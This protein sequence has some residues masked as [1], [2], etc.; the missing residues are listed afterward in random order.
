MKNCLVRMP[1]FLSLVLTPIIYT[2]TAK[3]GDN[4]K[5]ALESKELKIYFGSLTKDQRSSSKNSNEISDV[6]IDL[7]RIDY[8]TNKG[9]YSNSGKKSVKFN[10]DQQDNDDGNGISLGD[11][12][13]CSQIRLVVDKKKY[14]K[15]RDHFGHECTVKDAFVSIQLQKALNLQNKENNKLK[16]FLDMRESKFEYD[17]N[18]VCIFKPKFK[19]YSASHDKECIKDHEHDSDRDHDRERDDDKDHRG[20]KYAFYRN[21]DR[22]DRHSDSRN[23]ISNLRGVASQKCGG[24]NRWD[25]DDDDRKN[26]RPKQ[27][28][29]HG[30]VPVTPDPTPTPVPTPTPTPVPSPTPV[31]TP[32]PTP[33]PT[34]V[35]T[36]VPIPTPAPSPTPDPTPVVP[37]PT[38]SP[39]PDPTP[40]PVPTPTPTPTPVPVP[41][42]TPD[43]TPVPTP[44]PTPTP[45]PAPVPAPVLTNFRI[46]E[47]TLTG[48]TVG[49]T[50]DAA[51]TS[52]VIIT[53]L[54]TG[55]QTSTLVDATMTTTHQMYVD[56]LTPGVTYQLQAVSSNGSTSGVSATIMLAK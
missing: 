29:S 12:D 3:A 24:K 23:F 8:L 37:V 50:T 32:V 28:Q 20:G 16:I 36:P 38:P 19:V 26:H 25:D 56:N 49:W 39:T 31:P 34:P 40:A 13:G 44:T 47:V 10:R 5:Q 45:T 51:S 15:I 22:D 35:P 46:F 1:L 17:K 42:P 54:S 2:R 53:D 43:P 27:C 33:T 55:V 18:R 48:A 41:T 7:E 11:A 52:Q 4:R 14:G 9:W 6:Q 21:E 30:E